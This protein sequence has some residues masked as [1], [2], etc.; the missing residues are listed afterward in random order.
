MLSLFLFFFS[1][2][3][4]SFCDEDSDPIMSSKVIDP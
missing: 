1:V 4:R 3:L 2:F